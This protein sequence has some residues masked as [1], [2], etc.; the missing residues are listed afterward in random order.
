MRDRDAEALRREGEPADARDGVERSQL[1]LPGLHECGL[2][3]RPGDG[4]VG[5]ERDLV[6]PSL[7]RSSDATIGAAAGCVR[8][9]HLAVVAAGRKAFAV[10]RGAQDCAGVDSV[11]LAASIRRGEEDRFLAEHERRLAAEKMQAD[12]G[13]AIGRDRFRARGNG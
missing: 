12:N 10:A 4:I 7:L 2:A 11:T 6:D 3:G 13:R 9:D 1:A 8:H 5:P